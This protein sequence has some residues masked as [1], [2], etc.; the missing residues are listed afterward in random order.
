MRAIPHSCPPFY[1]RI[2]THFLAFRYKMTHP[3][4]HQIYIIPPAQVEGLLYVACVCTLYHHDGLSVM[5]YH[6]FTQIRNS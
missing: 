4:A 5:C 1:L 6:H 2:Q 3:A